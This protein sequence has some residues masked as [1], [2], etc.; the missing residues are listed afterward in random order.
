MIALSIRQPWAALI[1]HGVK[2][3]ENRS[4]RFNHR[5]LILI[6]A[7]KEPD[8]EALDA[9]ARDIHPVTGRPWEWPVLAMQFGGVVGCAEIV[10]CVGRHDSE[11]FVGPHGLVLARAR[12]LPFRPWPG[13]LGLFDIPDAAAPPWS[14]PGDKQ[15]VLW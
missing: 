1:V 3:V 5:G 8:A 11:W 12:A 9:A 15:G 10:D 7:G 4:R 6:H 14:P 2:P 13:Q